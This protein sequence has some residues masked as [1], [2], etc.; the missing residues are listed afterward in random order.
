VGE[1]AALS[2][3]AR[4]HAVENGVVVKA[5]VDVIQKVLGTDRRLDRVQFDF[6]LAV[7]GVQQHVRRFAGV[8]AIRLAANST[9]PAARASFFSMGQ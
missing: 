1:T 9:E 4:D 5:A 6:D 7:G 2:H 3:E 8:A